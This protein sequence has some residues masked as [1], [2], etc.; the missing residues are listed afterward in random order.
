MTYEEPEELKAKLEEICEGIKSGKHKTRTIKAE[1]E[2][3]QGLPKVPP[4]AL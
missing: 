1:L 4:D 2:S 3:A